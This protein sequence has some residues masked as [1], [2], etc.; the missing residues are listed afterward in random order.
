VIGAVRLVERKIFFDEPQAEELWCT[1]QLALEKLQGVRS[2]LE[3]APR[4]QA[5]AEE[6][7]H[8]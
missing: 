1:L 6:V 7:G 2:E 3:Y 8:G 5:P 4:A